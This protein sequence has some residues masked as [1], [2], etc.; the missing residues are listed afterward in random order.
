MEKKKLMA[1]DEI[2]SFITLICESF[3]F[4]NLLDFLPICDHTYN[5]YIHEVLTY[6]FECWSVHQFFQ[7]I[8]KCLCCFSQSISYFPYRKR[9]YK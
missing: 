9:V 1:K 8:W 6:P 2:K 5:R 3:K 4:S 7:L